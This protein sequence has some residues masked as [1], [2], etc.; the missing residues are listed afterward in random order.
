MPHTNLS[1]GL[2]NDDPR[3]VIKCKR[4]SPGARNRITKV[5]FTVQQMPIGV[6][7]RK[8]GVIVFGC[9]FWFFFTEKK[10]QRKIN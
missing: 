9:V 6:Q 4:S 2:R 7:S 10:E 1:N 5:Q 3:S 8:W